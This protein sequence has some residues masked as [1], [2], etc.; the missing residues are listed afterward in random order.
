MRHKKYNTFL[1]SKYTIFE[2]TRKLLSFDER[3]NADP[4]NTNFPQILE[5]FDKFTVSARIRGEIQC[6]KKYRSL[7]WSPELARQDD[8]IQYWKVISRFKGNI[9]D[10]HLG[11]FNP[12]HDVSN[13]DKTQEEIRVILSKEHLKRNKLRKHARKK[14]AEFLKKIA[15]NYSSMHDIPKV[16]AVKQI[17]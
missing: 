14:R 7:D 6:G 17:A 8:L 5:E 1:D 11:N 10:K 15:Y 13:F 4:E 2:L 3:V 16:A 9:S 12:K